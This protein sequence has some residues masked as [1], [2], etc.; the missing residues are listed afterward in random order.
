DGPADLR[1]A[2]ESGVLRWKF[3]PARRAGVAVAAT[4]RVPVMLVPPEPGPSK[5]AVP[6]RALKRIPP[7]YPHAMRVSGLRGDVVVEFV[8]DTQ[9]RVV[10]P[11]VVRTLNPA[12]NQ[13]ALEAVAKWTFEPGRLDG[14]PVNSKHQQSITFMLE[15]EP[16]GGDDGLEVKE[17]GDLN[18]LPEELRYDV[19]PK[20]EAFA[21]P[22]YPYELL[23]KRTRGSATVAL[24]IAPDGKIR[25]SKV[26]TAT[27]PEFGLALQAAAERFEYQPALKAGRPTPALLRFTQEFTP[28]NSTLVPEQAKEMLLIEKKR[29][30]RILKAGRVDRKPSPRTV[31]QPI[32]PST[33]LETGNGEALVEL[34]IDGEGRVQLPRVVSASAPEFGYAAVQAVS[35]WTFVP[36][37]S[38][39]NPVIV[40]V[41]VPFQFAAPSPAAAAPASP[42]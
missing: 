13:A 12:F 21:V 16:E 35:L 31:V 41:R 37:T 19:P 3:A 25:W 6:P 29:P 39:G 4:V 36:P 34:L 40:L 23:Q 1:A 42:E 28:S 9:G 2:I 33:L 20:L 17:R 38:G 14:R 26:V 5:N 22:A 32:F 30:E 10:S 8:V 7:V 24:M 27:H 15:G 11:T 18:K